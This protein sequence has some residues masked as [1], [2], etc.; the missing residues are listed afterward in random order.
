MVALRQP[1]MQDR[2][3]KEISDKMGIE[4]KP[5][6]EFTFNKALEMGLMK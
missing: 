3:W 2:H 6:P 4:V 1:G 5:N